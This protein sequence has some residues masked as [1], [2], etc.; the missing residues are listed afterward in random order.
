LSQFSPLFH[1]IHYQCLSGHRQLT[2]GSILTNRVPVF[3][4]IVE[5]ERNEP[6][7]VGTHYFKTSSAS[8]GHFMCKFFS[9]WEQFAPLWS[10]NR[11]HLPRTN[12]FQKKSRIIVV[13]NGVRTATINFRVFQM[14]QYALPAVF[15]I[16]SELFLIFML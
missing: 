1:T 5:R 12:V 8:P 2:Y 13:E 3:W 9:F 7:R 14:W 10:H 16:Y 4:R 6:G 11:F 15:F